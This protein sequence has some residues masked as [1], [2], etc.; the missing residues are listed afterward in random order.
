VLAGTW[1]NPAAAVDDARF[2]SLVGRATELTSTG[3]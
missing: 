1:N 2:I 3:D